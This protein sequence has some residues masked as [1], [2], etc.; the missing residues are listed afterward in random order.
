MKANLDIY[1]VRTVP[2]NYSWDLGVPEVTFTELTNSLTDVV[3]SKSDGTGTEIVGY[4]PYVGVIFSS[5]AGEYET[6]F[7]FL[8]LQREVDFGD[9]Y[10]SQTNL[11]KDST[12]NRVAF[13]HTYVMPGIYTVQFKRT[14]YLQAKIPNAKIIGSCLQKYC[15]EWSWAQLTS[16][17]NPDLLVTWKKTKSTKNLTTGEG[18]SSKKWAYEPCTDEWAGGDRIYVEKTDKID[19]Q[20]VPLTWQWFNFQQ[21]SP[22]NNNNTATT[23]ASAGFQQPEQLT[24]YETTGP[25]A[26]SLNYLSENT[27]WK[28]DYITS[29]TAFDPIHTTSLTWDDAV[30]TKPTRVTWDFTSQ[31]CP[32]DVITTVLSAQTDTITKQAYI[33]VLEIPI[34]A[35]L[36][37]IQPEDR[38]SPLTVI[39]SPRNIISGSFPIE[40][41]V[42]DLGDG[43]P[44][45]TQR[46]WAPTLQ[47]PFV[48]SGKINNDPQDPRN[49]DIEYSYIRTLEGPHA[50][51]PSL[52]AYSS[53]TGS[54]DIAAAV[55][56]PLLFSAKSADFEMN[57]IQ[58]ELTSQ[59]KVIIGEINN[60]L[61]VWRADK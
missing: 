20:R 34:K 26:F 8:G 2:S 57:L 12:T 29:N 53:S 31:Y 43:S 5:E 15:I 56:G 1:S 25:C 28:W 7:K 49:Y 37:V 46:R 61:A 55:V 47:K 23:W 51:Y 38:I 39:L 42:W 19:R 35:Y 11:I 6:D 9:Y 30:K 44:L 59:G 24:W 32:G 48:Y 18:L 40:K 41:I 54:Y 21:S 4:A 3:R 27:V 33:R 60:N 22:G 52:T 58:S 36:E 14:E 17:Y 16:L 10:N 13:C 45:L 50:F